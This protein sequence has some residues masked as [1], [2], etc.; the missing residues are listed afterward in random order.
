MTKLYAQRKDVF[1][2]DK[3][4]VV[5]NPTI[6]SEGGA[7]NFSS[8]SYISTQNSFNI[9]VSK[10]FEVNLS[11]KNIK[12]QPSLGD[13][14]VLQFITETGYARFTLRYNGK[15]FYLVSGGANDS[16]STGIKYFTYDRD[17]DVD[18]IFGLKGTTFYGKIK[19]SYETDWRNFST[20]TI[21]IDD[22]FT[23]A[24]ISFGRGWGNYMTSDTGS[25]D[26]S[27]FSITVDGKEVFT[28]A[29]EKFYA[30]RGGK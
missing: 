7:T 26:L 12:Y 6:T 30:M 1:D 28:G 19:R 13:T 8:S 10:D 27:Q 11:L 22:T 20:T 5:G 3:I 9:D 18:I 17:M 23:N 2:I 29:K 14:G 16:E 24:Y 25:I 15:T 4:T 21:T